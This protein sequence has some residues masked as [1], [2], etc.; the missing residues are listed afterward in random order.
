MTL[1]SGHFLLSCF[2]KDHTVIKNWLTVFIQAG[3]T[4]TSSG[5]IKYFLTECKICSKLI[6][7][8]TSDKRVNSEGSLKQLDGEGKKK[9]QTHTHTPCKQK[10]THARHQCFSLTGLRIFNAVR[11]AVLYDPGYNFSSHTWALQKCCFDKKAL[12]SCRTQD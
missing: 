6:A 2:T 10:T 5:N 8:E 7:W 9:T 12:T 4:R 1:T 11:N 3:T